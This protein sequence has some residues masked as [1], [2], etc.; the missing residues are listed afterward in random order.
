MTPRVCL[1]ILLLSLPLWAAGQVDQRALD[2]QAAYPTTLRWDNVEATWP[3]LDGVAPGYRRAAGMH[4]FRLDPG[5]QTHLQLPARAWLRLLGQGADGRALSGL[6]VLAANG[7]GLYVQQQPQRR[8]AGDWLLAPGRDA[9]LDILIRNPVA[10]GGPVELALFVS[11]WVRPPALAPYRHPVRFQ[12]PAL[13]LRLAGQVS[14]RT[15]WALGHGQTLQTEVTGP[16]RYRLET[17]LDY[18]QAGSVALRDY[19]LGIRLDGQALRDL[20]FDNAPEV[21]HVVLIDGRPNPVGQRQQGYI[22]IPA[23]RHRLRLHSATPVFLRLLRSAQPDYLLPGLNQPVGL[24]TWRPRKTV[25]GPDMALAGLEHILTAG[26]DIDAIE[27]AADRITSD[28]RH[29]DGGLLAAMAL[30]G[31]A[32]RYPERAGIA[33]LAHKTLLRHSYYQ[34]LMP[35]RGV[36]GGRME[37][38]H[39]SLREPQDQRDHYVADPRQLAAR[40]GG[41]QQAYFVTLGD[42]RKLEYR[43]PA[44]QTPSLLRIAVTGAVATPQG[45]SLVFDDGTRWRLSLRPPEQDPQRLRVDAAQAWSG[46]HT[47]LQA[48]QTAVEAG[49]WELALPAGV[50]RIR[51]LRQQGQGAP[52]RLAL[53]YRRARPWRMADAD[54]VEAWRDPNTAVL[55]REALLQVDTLLDPDPAGLRQ[56]ARASG[57]DRQRAWDLLNHWTPLLRWLRRQREQY[58]ASVGPGGFVRPAHPLRAPDQVR[59]RAQAQADVAAGQWLSALED[60]RQLVSS[61]DSGL[62]REARLGMADALLQQGEPRLAERLLRSSFLYAGD[63][64]LRNAAFAWLRTFYTEQGDAAGLAGLSITRLLRAPHRDELGRLPG[65]LRDNGLPD[66]ALDVALLLPDQGPDRVTGSTSAP[67]LEAELEL[68]LAGRRWAVFEP[69]LQGL[70]PER[71]ELWRGYRAQAGGDLEGARR[72]WGRAGAAGRDLLAALDLGRRIAARRPFTAG[73]PWLTAWS[74]WLQSLP[75]SHVWRRAPELVQGDA[76]LARLY[77][78]SLDQHI[79]L[80]RADAGRSLRLHVHGPLRLRFDIRPVH[81]AGEPEGVPLQGWL[82]VREADR[83]WVAPISNNLPNTE[84]QWPDSHGL[85]AG[86]RVQTELRLGPGAHELY[87]DAGDMGLLVRVYAEQPLLPLTVL[88]A[89]LPRP[90]AG[91]PAAGI[92]PTVNCTPVPG[93]GLRD[94][95]YAAAGD[96]LPAGHGDTPRGEDAPQAVPVPVGVLVASRP[97]SLPPLVR[98]GRQDGLIRAGDNLDLDTGDWD[99]YRRMVALLWELERRDADTEAYLDRLLALSGQQ[100]HQVQT[101]RLLA[102]ALRYSGWSLIA[103]V[104]E[105]AGVRYVRRPAVRPA[106]PSLR[107]RLALMG[108]S[109]AGDRLLSSDDELVYAMFNTRPVTLSLELRRCEPPYVQ[110]GD[111]R[112]VLDDGSGAAPRRFHMDGGQRLL[113]RRIRVP[114]GN[115]RIRLRIADP[116]VNQF[117]AVRI[118]DPGQAGEAGISE[119]AFQ[120]ASRSE[121]VRFDI[122]GPAWL[123]VDE[124]RDGRLHSQYLPVAR[125]WQRVELKPAPGRQESLYRIWRRVPRQPPAPARLRTSRVVMTAVPGPLMRLPDSGPGSDAALPQGDDYSLAGQEDGS[126]S[127]G[128]G[129]TSRTRVDNESGVSG[130][131]RENFA[132]FRAEYRYFDPLRRRYWKGEGFVRAREFGGPTL[133]LG[134]HVYTTPWADW[135]WLHISAHLGTLIQ[136]PGDTL[137]GADGRTEWIVNAS[138]RT[139]AHQDLGPRVWHEPA[140]TLFGRMLSLQRNKRYSGKALDRD[141]FSRY[142]AQHQRGLRLFDTL[143][144]RPWLDTEWFLRTGLASNEDFDLFSPDNVSGRIGWRQLFGPVDAEARLRVQRFLVDGD[145]RKAS[146]RRDLDLQLNWMGWPWMQQ[147]LALGLRFSHNLNRS[148]NSFILSLSWQGGNGR[149]YRDFRRSEIDFSDLRRRDVPERGN[150][151]PG[152]ERLP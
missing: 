113:T 137:P 30:R 148:D 47:G 35:E 125:G 141:V 55:F 64:K 59:L 79:S 22:D 88:P 10:T 50:R 40:Q 26:G 83:E 105:S 78:P 151:L 140:L 75:G 51:I 43:L 63:E 19:R 37:F 60:W 70:V 54:Y 111:L 36:A 139:L 121:P 85:L 21:R 90:G 5:Q 9:V 52:L 73:S 17:R 7:S 96:S 114:A 25:T 108:D 145:R 144:W 33:A 127:L 147:R 24:A 129:L 77:S 143:T 38:Y 115:Q 116:V 2:L 102:R 93:S 12:G 41:H 16:A 3:W 74:R 149:G 150:R 29:R 138:L 128:F 23:G 34:D 61:Q 72:H 84:L 142:K 48:G 124:L 104:P 65:I 4:V 112:M 110:P 109:C 119:Q 8:A 146:T 42:T 28:N 58:A 86:R 100:A 130:R 132:E 39:R 15:V 53:Q 14:V 89:G 103:Y 107:A 135:P 117:V 31:L 133:G 45:L 57:M 11:R 1:C 67:L 91:L 76:G 94:C 87:L 92:E 49:V 123:R 120:V 126:L 152:M 95:R 13:G 68:A 131:L 20:A 82:Q 80:Y 56:L 99:D 71:V 136:H 66:M 18:R 27:A 101:R 44:R 32:R 46:L 98:L 81:A 97:A 62:A 118:I 134:G 122:Q 106:S 69:L 6:E